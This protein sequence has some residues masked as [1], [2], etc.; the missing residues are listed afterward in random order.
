MP[1]AVGIILAGVIMIMSSL[2]ESTRG[3]MYWFYYSRN[4][5]ADMKVLATAV[6]QYIREGGEQPSSTAMQPLPTSL[7]DITSAP[8]YEYI[9]FLTTMEDGANQ[10]TWFGFSVSPT[11]TD[12]SWQFNRVVVAAFDP[13]ATDAATYFAS[14]SCGVDAT[15]SAKGATTATS[16]CGS[17]KS[18]WFRYETRETS[19]KRLSLQRARMNVLMQKITDWYNANGGVFPSK[20]YSGATLAVNSATKLSAMVNFTVGGVPGGKDADHWAASKCQ[21]I[22]TWYTIPID[23][24]DMYDLWG[25]AV[26]YWYRGPQSI[27]LVTE[28]PILDNLGNKILVGADMDVSH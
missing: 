21:G 5:Q 7:N 25:G 16:W 27:A 24:Q 6:N 1:T 10:K 9:R 22:R 18:L 19:A 11:I 15:D 3:D 4:R 12:T 28:S 8:G 14:N 13:T 23:C 26:W 17:R 2:L 20:D